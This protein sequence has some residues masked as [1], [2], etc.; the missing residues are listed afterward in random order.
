[1][2][3]QNNLVEIRADAF[4]FF[5][6]QPNNSATYEELY[7]HLASINKYVLHKKLDSKIKYY[8]PD[9]LQV[10]NE[11]TIA[12]LKQVY[13]DV[14]DYPDEPKLRTYIYNGGLDKIKNILQQS[15]KINASVQQNRLNILMANEEKRLSKEIKEQQ[16][17]EKK[18]K[19]ERENTGFQITRKSYV[20]TK[21]G[22][23]LTVFLACV[24]IG[25]SIYDIWWKDFK[26]ETRMIQLDSTQVEQNKRLIELLETKAHKD[27]VIVINQIPAK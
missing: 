12:T 16:Q 13:F 18:E 26:H 27:T 17:K 6:M 2:S 9:V 15:Y 11:F 25:I 1:M 23:W 3:K 8:D 5:Q 7:S 22:I 4:D 21:R 10:F 24:Q 14:V 19:D 20:W